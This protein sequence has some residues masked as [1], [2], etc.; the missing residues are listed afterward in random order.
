MKKLTLIVL[1]MSLGF[2]SMNSYA[3]N[4]NPKPKCP[5]GQIPVLE[6]SHWQCKQP[7]IK[8]KQKEQR[9]GLLL[10][11]VQKV[12]EAASRTPVRSSQAG[13]KPKCR[14]GTLAMWENGHWMC[15]QPHLAAPTRQQR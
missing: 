5:M 12:R 4:P 6:G 15:K 9:V 2:L 10:P 8:A 3:N 11:A 1:A 7:D 14:M 13:P